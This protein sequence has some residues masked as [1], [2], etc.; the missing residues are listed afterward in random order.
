MIYK[1]KNSPKIKA[2]MKANGLGI[3]D[4]TKPEMMKRTGASG[5]HLHIGKD[6][7]GQTFFGQKGFKFPLVYKPE[8]LVLGSNPFVLQTPRE[9][10]VPYMNYQHPEY[11]DYNDTGAVYNAETDH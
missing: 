8:P 9:N 3:I 1:I 10:H 6:K 5:P 7:A 11:Y 4:E 2:Y